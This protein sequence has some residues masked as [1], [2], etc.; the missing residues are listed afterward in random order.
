VKLINV[1]GLTLFGPGS[2]W[3]WS[4]LQLIVVAISLIGLY[5]QLRL[6]ASAGAIEQ[7][8]ALASDWNSE[9][10]HRSRLATLLPLQ[11]G[12][13]PG[14]SSSQAAIEIGNYWERVGWLVRSGHIDRRLVYA[15]LGNSV[16]LWWKL[17]APNTHQL[18]QLQRD[19]QIF[20]HFEW[21][22]NAIETMDR[23]TG[24]TLN[25]DDKAY[26]AQLIESG[27]ERSQSAIQL[28]EQLRAVLVHPLSVTTLTPTRTAEAG[29]AAPQR[30][31]RSRDI[32]GR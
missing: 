5:R 8:T 6:Q 18:R 31:P 26:V 10:L 16:R 23:Q 7:A 4:M 2:E 15:Y 28:A 30:T 11:D 21:L 32:R 1:D 29:S 17:L 22:A 14:G 20:E 13:D 12:V 19:E 9:L 27:I 24:V 3:L 25:Y